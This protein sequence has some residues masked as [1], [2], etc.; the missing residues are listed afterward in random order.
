M[1]SEA[2]LKAIGEEIAEPMTKTLLAAVKRFDPLSGPNVMRYADQVFKD[3]G[4]GTMT[5]RLRQTFAR[6]T[7][8]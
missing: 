5:M 2:K 4:D 1:T 3:N 8:E 7:G 6:K